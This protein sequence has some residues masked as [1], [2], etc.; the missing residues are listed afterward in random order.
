MKRILA[1]IPARAGSKGIPNKNLRLI[2]GYPLVYYALNN[3]IQSK[4]ITDII[5]TTDSPLIGQLAKQMGAKVHQRPPELCDDKTTLDSVIYDAIPK[6]S[7]WDYIIT[8]Q[9]TSP[10][11]KVDSLDQAIFMAIEK[12]LDTVLSVINTPHLSWTEKNGQI[13]PNYTVRA[14]RQYLP[15]EYSETGAFVIS[16]ASVVT[17]RT[18]IGKK[19][20]VFELSESESVDIDNFF[21]LIIAKNILKNDHIGFYVNG[22]SSIGTGHIYRV[23][24]LADEFDS[25]PDIYYDLNQTKPKIFGDTTHHMI[26]VENQYDLFAKLQKTAY[27]IFIND[28]LDT[29]TDYMSSLRKVLP[30]SKIINFEDEGEG[31]HLADLTINALYA[32]SNSPK[33]RSGSDYFIANKNFLFCPPINIRPQVQKILITFGGADP[34]KYTEQ[35]L[36]IIQSPEYKKYH[37]TILFGKAKENSNEIIHSIKSPNIQAF[38]DVKNIPEI[39]SQHDLAITSRGRTCYELAI[40]GIPTL[41]MAQNEREERHTFANS[42][43]GFTYIGMSPSSTAIKKSL[44]DFLNSSI[45]TR[46]HLQYLMLQTNL[47][48]GRRHCIQ[49]INNIPNRK[50]DKNVIN[51]IFNR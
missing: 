25:K 41:V 49:A 28:I 36:N 40:L 9:P 15:P 47:K 22:N 23:L 35:I 1:I 34:Q 24:E 46:R 29:N 43:N 14:N 10:T 5:V 26:P 12:D 21:D 17:N 38:R 37:F 51:T 20:N 7:D 44:D 18:R 11:L 13:T 16:K 48:Q 33:I 50:E 42:D 27:S 31:S 19:I 3:A 32:K 8:M 2:N 30:T 39:M 4:Y 45:E 6:E